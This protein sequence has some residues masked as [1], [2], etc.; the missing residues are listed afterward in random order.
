MHMSDEVKV[1]PGAH[2]KAQADCVQ[3]GGLGWV[4]EAG[5]SNDPSRKYVPCVCTKD[6][7]SG[8][9][10]LGLLVGLAIGV[11]ALVINAGGEAQMRAD[12][13]GREV[14]LM[15]VIV[16]EPGKSALT[17]FGPAAAGAG[18]GWA[19]EEM[20]GGNSGNQRNTSIN[21][22]G[23]E[24]TVSVNVGDSR[25]DNRTDTRTDTRSDGSYNQ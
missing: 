1:V 25:S 23:N 15:D 22:D 20:S 5:Y 11:A 10:V 24:G 13:S 9:V 19:L 12:A 3:C 21:I 4:L 6:D 2:P 17:V 8:E 18:I 16:D 14:A 7:K